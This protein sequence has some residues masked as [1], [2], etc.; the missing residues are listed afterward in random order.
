MQWM[1]MCFTVLATQVCIAHVIFYL[2]FLMLFLL[3]VHEGQ[4]LNFYCNDC[5]SAICTLC[6]DME[7]RE[8]KTVQLET[9]ANEQSQVLQQILELSQA[10]ARNLSKAMPPHFKR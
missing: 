1:K 9:A 2:V 10:Q 8:H 3:F 4:S 5:D 7:H 6:T